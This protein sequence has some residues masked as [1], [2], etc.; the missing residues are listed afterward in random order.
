LPL[1]DEI[2]EILDF[3]KLKDSFKDLNDKIYKFCD[4][5]KT[6]NEEEKPKL[7]QD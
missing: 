7:K 4:N 2:I 5:F 1:E 6:I 3:I